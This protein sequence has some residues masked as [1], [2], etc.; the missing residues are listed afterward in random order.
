MKKGVFEMTETFLKILTA[1]YLAVMLLG[2]FFAINN[3]YLYFEESE[4][5]RDVLSLTD[6]MMSASCLV[7]TRDKPMEMHY[8]VKGLLKQSKLETEDSKSQSCVKF[9]KAFKY[10][11]IN[12]ET[13][14]ILYTLGDRT[15]GGEDVNSMLFPAAMNKSN[16]DV[17]PVILN[18]TVEQ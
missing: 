17:I 10:D 8:T 1:G 4:V 11:V 15:V 16:G 7:E 2:M 12:S 6:G 5:N 9:G 18:V 3:Y 14:S 13:G